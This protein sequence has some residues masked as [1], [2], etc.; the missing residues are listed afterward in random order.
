MPPSLVHFS[1]TSQVETLMEAADKRTR[2]MCLGAQALT[3]SLLLA[4]KLTYIWRSDEQNM[5]KSPAGAC[6]WKPEWRRG[7]K[8]TRWNLAEQ[9]R[10]VA[11]GGRG[12][13]FLQFK[14][15]AKRRAHTRMVD[16]ESGS[17][18]VSRVNSCAAGVSSLSQCAAAALLRD[19]CSWFL[20]CWLFHSPVKKK[21]KKSFYT[22]TFV[23]ICWC[24]IRSNQ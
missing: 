4:H 17:C 3:S 13:S 14:E 16:E 12:G 23:I 20:D 11:A 22:F 18:D 6:R 10:A 24:F 2:L 7:W 21:K 5:L 19:I 8:S 9:S 1:Q 15:G